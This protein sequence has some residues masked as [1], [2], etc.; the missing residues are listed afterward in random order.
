V[1]NNGLKEGKGW[2]LVRISLK[3]QEGEPWDL[4]K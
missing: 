1:D 3:R 2:E 4:K